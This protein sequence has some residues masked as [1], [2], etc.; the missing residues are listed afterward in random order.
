MMSKGKEIYAEKINNLRLLV[1][2]TDEE[3][4]EFAARYILDSKKENENQSNEF[5]FGL[6]A[7][8]TPVKLY[9]ILKKSSQREE[10]SW[11]RTVFFTIDELAELDFSHPA[12][13]R[14]WMDRYFLNGL[15][16]D[17]KKFF[18]PNANN[19]DEDHVYEE[20]I[21]QKPIDVQI[22][23]LGLNGHIAY[24]EP[25]TLFSSKTHFVQLTESSRRQ[26][27]DSGF[28]TSFEKIPKRAITV[29]L[30]TIMKAKS[31]LLMAF[32]KHKAVIVKKILA[33]SMSPDFP[34]T[35]LRNHK[36]CFLIVDKQA[37]SLFLER[38]D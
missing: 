5:R 32:G 13:F 2:E 23:G 33:S 24:C 38:K 31:I 34:A 27:K 18:S 20:L 17:A 16:I 10:I 30:L 26:L 37:A 22:L 35:I 3:G 14:N 4:S 28:F 36:N 21:T 6:A 25:G 12:L 8:N 11:K 15:E 9:E 29:G 7:G 1:F 19:N